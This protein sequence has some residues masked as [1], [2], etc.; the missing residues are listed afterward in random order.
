MLHDETQLI[1]RNCP[2]SKWRESLLKS[3]QCWT[4]L[5]HVVL[6]FFT[7]PISV[8]SQNMH[9]SGTITQ[10]V[11]CLVAQVGT[12]WPTVMPVLLSWPENLTAIFHIDISIIEYNH[13]LKNHE[14]LLSMMPTYFFLLHHPVSVRV[15]TSWTFWLQSSFKFH[16][17]SMEL[18]RLAIFIGKG[19][20]KYYS[21][22][23]CHTVI[24][25]LY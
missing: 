12:D 16:H 3:L 18:G 1:S 6:F 21:H 5:Q 24:C 22:A 8:S 7:F 4:F 13:V 20:L 23:M 9:F 2:D 10:R 14:K 15:V 25:A 17:Y 19:T 11:L